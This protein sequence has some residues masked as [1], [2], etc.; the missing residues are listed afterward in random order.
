MRTVMIWLTGRYHVLNSA[1]FIAQ[2]KT[3]FDLNIKPL[4][5]KSRAIC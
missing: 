4:H 5:K 3:E 2:Q 1:L